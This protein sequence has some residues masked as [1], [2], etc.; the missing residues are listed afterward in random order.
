MSVGSTVLSSFMAGLALG[1]LWCGR[2]VDRRPRA[3]A[4]YAGL[5]ASIALSAVLLPVALQA[6]TPLYVWL[7]Q[8]LAGVFWLFSLVRFLLAFTLLCVPTSLMGATL[9]VLSRYIVRNDAAL[10][11]SVG[12][13][14]AL[15]TGGA[16]VG[17]FVAGY[18]LLGRVGLSRTV[19]IGAAL[20][21]AIALVVWVGR[22]R[23]EE[24]ARLAE[25]P[26]SPPGDAPHA[27][28]VY[29]EKIVRR[30]LWSFA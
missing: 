15:N 9:P 13:L 14:Y 2:Y 29:D 8:H 21:L 18:V 25:T 23:M 12:T 20:N 1:S 22:P 17:C 7:H 19:W 27:A 4:L 11:W 5:E 6:L 28:V 30:V 10:G 16:V 3:L 24:A 26:L